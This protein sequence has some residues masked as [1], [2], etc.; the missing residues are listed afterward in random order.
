M[1]G[2]RS[3]SA[4]KQE[5]KKSENERKRRHQ[6]RAQTS[7]SG[8]YYSFLRRKSLRALLICKFDDQ[9]SVLTR[10]PD[11]HHQSDLSEYVVWQPAYEVERKSAKD[12]QWDRKQNDERCDQA[13]ILRSQDQKQTQD[14][15]GED[16]VRLASVA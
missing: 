15:E 2:Q 4:G 11:Q 8:F 16:Q 3:G 1:T 9:N 12:R 7:L 5:R 10:K 14:T 6:D 13:F